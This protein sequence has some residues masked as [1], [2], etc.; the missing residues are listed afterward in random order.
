MGGQPKAALDIAF[1][2]EERWA[3]ALLLTRKSGYPREGRFQ[4]ISTAVASDQ[5]GLVRFLEPN[6]CFDML[7]LSLWLL[8]VAPKALQR[9]AG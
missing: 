2:L 1:F 8:T 4:P 9:K 5:A 7:F 6:R 3:E